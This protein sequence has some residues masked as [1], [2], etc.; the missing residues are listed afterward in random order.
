[1]PIV[2][3]NRLYLGGTDVTSFYMH[4]E[5]WGRGLLRKG[6]GEGESGLRGLRAGVRIESIG[7]DKLR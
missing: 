2:L 3:R 7:P 1:M 4:F 6:N 5:K